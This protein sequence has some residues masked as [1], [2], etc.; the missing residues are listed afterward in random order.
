MVGKKF[1][2]GRK[3]T[4]YAEP[5]LQPNEG[6]NEIQAKGVRKGA[7]EELRSQ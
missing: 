4:T 5:L 2:E 3:A 7:T 6:S 1:K